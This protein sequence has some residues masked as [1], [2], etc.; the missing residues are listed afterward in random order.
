MRRLL[1]S[2][3]LLTQAISYFKTASSLTLSECE[4][5][6]LRL[7]D[8][9][10][11]KESNPASVYVDGESMTLKRKIDLNADVYGVFHD[12]LLSTGWGVLEFKAGYGAGSQRIH[13]SKLFKA[14]G[15][16]EG[17][18]TAYRIQQ[19]ICNTFDQPTSNI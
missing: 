6:P 9:V 13:T 5:L 14:A 8:S 2:A 3:F 12:R 18:L 7:K 19:H 11:R 16:L 10:P 4:E 1:F 15:Y 17:Y